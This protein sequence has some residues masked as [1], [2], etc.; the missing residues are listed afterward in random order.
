[1][2]K[3]D[4][5]IPKNGP[6][7][8]TALALLLAGWGL[9]LI[10]SPL[11][12]VSFL[13]DSYYKTVFGMIFL[14]IVFLVPVVMYLH[15]KQP[16]MSIKA[17]FR[18]SLPHKRIWPGVMLFTAGLLILA[19]ATD[20]LLMRWLEIPPEYFSIL[21]EMKWSGPGQAILMIIAVSGVAAFAEEVIFRGMLLQSMEKSFR[22]PQTAI[23]MSALFFAL[24]HAMP[25]YF[26]QIIIL[27]I[28][29]GVLSSGFQ[30]VWP[31]IVCH[32]AYNLFSMVLLNLEPVPEW[33][34]FDGNVRN[35][36]VLVA[37][38]L[39]WFGISQLRHWFHLPEPPD[40]GL[41][42]E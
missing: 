41:E 36:W 26:F 42:K 14:E 23:I 6:P 34:V 3:Q 37:G 33:Y 39:L 22:K 27:G 10:L 38:V 21:E 2:I 17:V 35:R 24:V 11:L 5:H 19:D 12:T 18:L 7:L 4:S 40:T 16:G 28:I 29:L 32:G 15:K 30:S 8:K 20:R 9:S 25:W 13:P 1:M 31:A